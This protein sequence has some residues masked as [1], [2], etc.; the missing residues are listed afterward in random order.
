MMTILLNDTIL[1]SGEVNSLG[2]G[3]LKSQRPA[4]ATATFLYLSQHCSFIQ[5]CNGGFKA[6]FL[7]FNKKMTNVIL[8]LKDT[9]EVRWT[10]RGCNLTTQLI[11]SQTQDRSSRTNCWKERKRF[12]ISVMTQSWNGLLAMDLFGNTAAILNSMGRLGIP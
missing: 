1:I 9:C 3:F 10:C 6:H 2:L 12:T 5:F 4:S 8:T 7:R 11:Q